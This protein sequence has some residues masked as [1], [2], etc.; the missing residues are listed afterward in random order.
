MQEAEVAYFKL[1]IRIMLMTV[2]YKVARY[3]NH[4]IMTP[5]FHKL[6]R[7]AIQLKL[8]KVGP[9][10]GPHA[11]ALQSELTYKTEVNQIHTAKS[12]HQYPYM[13]ERFSRR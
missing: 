8:C 7:C 12:K 3:Y 1:P 10:G 5:I 9:N 6:T 13:R 2:I 4:K 11:N